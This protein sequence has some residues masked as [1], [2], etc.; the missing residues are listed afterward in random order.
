MSRV[1]RGGRPSRR[2]GNAVVSLV[3]VTGSCAALAGLG[4]W[5][6]RSHPT[7]FWVGSA[8][9]VVAWIG[10]TVAETAIDVRDRRQKAAARLA[11]RTRERFLEHLRDG[12][13]GDRERPDAGP[14]V[15]TRQ[16][17]E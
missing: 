9:F 8:A 13:T 17:G 7:T 14:R 11:T 1:V 3:L 6:W 2:D 12:S 16:K 15:P 4:L 10:F 5:L